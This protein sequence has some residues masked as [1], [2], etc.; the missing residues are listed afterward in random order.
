MGG[1]TPLV[2]Y[3]QQEM[4]DIFQQIGALTACGRAKHGSSLRNCHTKTGHSTVDFDVYKQYK[5]ILFLLLSQYKIF[6]H[7]T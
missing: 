5:P 6:I 2:T 1:N 3:F 7:I 4:S